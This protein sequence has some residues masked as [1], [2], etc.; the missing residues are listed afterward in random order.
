MSNASAR[1]LRVI[2]LEG[3]MV[4]AVSQI[5]SLPTVMMSL[6]KQDFFQKYYISFS[7]QLSTLGTETNQIKW[8][9]LK[10]SNEKKRLPKNLEE[11][12]KYRRAAKD[13][14]RQVTRD[15]ASYLVS[16]GHHL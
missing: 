6:M 13:M 10:F 4:N 3:Y 16:F 12:C 15:W 9:Q 8:S 5:M 2:K 14:G 7:A 1:Y 11:S